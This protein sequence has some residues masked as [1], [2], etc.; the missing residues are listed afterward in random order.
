VAKGIIPP[1]VI[2]NLT[3]GISDG[4]P[5]TLGPNQVAAAYDVDYFDADVVARRHGSTALTSSLASPYRGLFVHT[6][7]SA[8]S[9]NLL[10]QVT[11]SGVWNYRNVSNALTAVTPA[12]AD[13]FTPTT[14]VDAVSLH[15]KL[16]IACKSDVNRMHAWDGTTLRRAGLD[17]TTAAPTGADTGGAGSYSG[18]RYFRVRWTVQSGGSTI[19]RSEPSSVLTIV[20]SG[21]NTGIVVTRP[22]AAGEG[23]T[24]WELEEST[25][26]ANF[27]RMAT[28]VIATTTAT[29]TTAFASVAS[30]GTLSEDIGDYTP[31]WSA[32]WV[33]ADNDRL[34][35]GGSFE[36]AALDSRVAW[37]QLPSQTGVGNDERVPTDASNYYDADAKQGGGLTGLRAYE[38][39]IL[40]F[41][42]SRIYPYIRT[43][44]NGV[45]YMPGPVVR[46]HGALPYSVC[47]GYDRDNRT[48][49]YFLDPSTGP[50]EVGPQG[51]RSLASDRLLRTWQST[52][53]RS[54]T[55]RICNA[56]YYPDKRQV[57]WN[58][59]TTGN[60]T[61]NVR[62]VYHTESGGVT[63][64]TIPDSGASACVMWLDKPTVATGTKLLKCD[65][66]TATD[67]A[68]TNY[69]AYIKTR[70][71]TL[72]E[73][74]QEGGV[75]GAVLEA[76]P[77]E[78]VVLTL[79]LIRD[80]GAETQSFEADLTPQGSEEFVIVPMDDVAIS[81]SKVVQFELGDDEARSVAAWRV[82][83]LALT[84]KTESKVVN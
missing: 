70:A 28:T 9:G 15:G 53:N 29:D 79:T 78:D 23:E 32:R 72:A 11:A 38:N 31:F 57:W 40:A 1:L 26:N 52:I 12:P 33:T 62:W 69:R 22:T 42:L 44:V 17:D 45:A 35:V 59:S 50:A 39:K 3:G 13:T 5:P 49:I 81:E 64:H 71:Y 36:D 74:V 68:G 34:V 27:Y 24:H 7:T 48:T 25:D 19:L 56:L 60:N 63:F 4:H 10:F 8:A 73:L 58:L 16:F 20:P 51:V 66:S 14:G 77:A 47:E 55:V 61:P 37:S 67:D 76:D 2:D 43:G 41:K 84:A 82:H 18:T 75:K 83:R 65:D 80:Y 54:A 30:T 46:T 6:P 21:S